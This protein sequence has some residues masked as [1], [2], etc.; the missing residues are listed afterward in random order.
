MTTNIQKRDIILLSEKF[1]CV[2]KDLEIKAKERNSL[3]TSVTS[4][5]SAWK[6]SKEQIKQSLYYQLSDSD[7]FIDCDMLREIRG[8]KGRKAAVLQLPPCRLVRCHTGMW[9]RD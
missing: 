9:I 8:T 4:T 5:E 3:T 1:S 2:L 7:V 6:A